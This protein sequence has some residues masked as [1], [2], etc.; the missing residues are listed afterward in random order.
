MLTQKA[1]GI[2]H[3]LSHL[4]GIAD[5]I[6]KLSAINAARSENTIVSICGGSCTGKT[7][8]VASGLL[9]IVGADAQIVSQD[10]FMLE[11]V[12]KGLDKEP[13]RWDH[14]DCFNVSESSR[15]MDELRKNHRSSMPVYSFQTRKFEGLKEI[16]PSRIVLFEGLYSGYKSL[17]EFSDYRI[18]VEM[19]LYARLI[20]RLIRNLYERYQTTEPQAILEGYI[21]ALR[22]H[23]DFVQ[24]QRETADSILTPNYD[25]R[26]AI[27]RF[28]LAPLAETETGKTLFEF[29]SLDNVTIK[30]CSKD[31]ILNFS[32]AQLKNIYFH[33]EIG[34]STFETLHSLDFTAV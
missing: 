26:E 31:N 27:R 20:R 17:R 8:Q 6:L 24:T 19:P 30:I 2:V 28:N 13:Y 10:Q 5:E 33:F 29:T 1:P 25:F 14:P 21:R 22:A 16:V 15:V 11:S 4:S 9:D 12:A 3:G 34:K 7:T 23:G 32:V 18:Y